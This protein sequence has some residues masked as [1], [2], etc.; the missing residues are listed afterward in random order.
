MALVAAASRGLGRAVAVELAAEGA[1]LIICSRQ[2]QAIE[3][4]ATEIAAE[5][6]ADILALPC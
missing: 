5:T 2:A 1:A 6:G 4:T 3:R